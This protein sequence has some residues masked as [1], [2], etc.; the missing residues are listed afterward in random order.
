L[1]L[2]SQP[3]L[4]PLLQTSFGERSA[5]ISPDGRWLAYQSNESGQSEIYVRRTADVNG[6]RWIVSR[7]G[8]QHALWARNGRELFYA[9]ATGGL[10][11][12]AVEGGSAWKA[13]TPAKLLDGPY[14][15]TIPNFG[16]R[17]YDISPDGQRFL[18]L[19]QVDTPEPSTIVVVQNWFDEL[20]RLV[21]AK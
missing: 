14:I 5:E 10:M 20:K 21:P 13:G 6:G 12:V 4:E 18:V 3:R 15:L 9:V 16:G 17:L 11:H 7:G 2:D 8:G 1:T 19:K